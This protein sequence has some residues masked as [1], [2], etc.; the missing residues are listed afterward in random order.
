[1]KLRMFVDL[2]VEINKYPSALCDTNSAI[3]ITN[4]RLRKY[5]YVHTSSVVENPLDVIS[6]L[7]MPFVVGIK[8]FYK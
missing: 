1:M 5:M 3:N 6:G 2:Q 8:L 4:H 7:L